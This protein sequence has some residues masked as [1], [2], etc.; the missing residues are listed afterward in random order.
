MGTSASAALSSMLF[1]ICGTSGAAWAFNDDVPEQVP[2]YHSPQRCDHKQPCWK[3][4]DPTKE[5][6]D[7]TV[8]T[9]TPDAKSQVGV[10]FVV[11]ASAAFAE[12]VRNARWK[13]VRVE[14]VY[15]VNLAEGEVAEITYTVD[16]RKYHDVIKAHK[17]IG[18]RMT[19]TI[20]RV[21]A[22]YRS[23]LDVTAAVVVPKVDRATPPV[24]LEEIR[25]TIERVQ[26]PVLP[27]PM[28]WPD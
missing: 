17:P 11:P 14:F 2:P 9:V 21:V 3:A 16:G 27:W 13:N 28:G 8:Y 5:R 1:V 26:P 6:F 10:S 19:R 22:D 18:E 12:H 25:F 15:I 24:T 4:L 20:K 7:P 23:H